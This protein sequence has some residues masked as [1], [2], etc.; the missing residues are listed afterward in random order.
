[1]SNHMTFESSVL[2]SPIQDAATIVAIDGSRKGNAHSS[3]YLSTTGEFG[4]IAAKFGPDR[5]KPHCALSTE[6][7]AAYYGLRRVTHENVTILSDNQSTVTWLECWKD[8]DDTLPHWY[9]LERSGGK[10]STIESLRTVVAARA[11]DL[12]VVY[13][14]GHAGDLLN[15]AAD[16]LAG[17]GSNVINRVYGKD[18]AKRRSV[19]IAESFLS[20]YYEG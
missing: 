12:T 2:V 14:K 10:K 8:G 18:E 17:I 20:S 13:T 1:M 4:V 19:G 5:C 11:L 7:R 15:E 6:L 9:T 3:A 16:A